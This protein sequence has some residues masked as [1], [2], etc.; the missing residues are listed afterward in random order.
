[1]SMLQRRFGQSLLVFIGLL[2]PLS[3]TPDMANTSI[4]EE[5]PSPCS[6]KRRG[7]FRLVGR[8]RTTSTPSNFSGTYISLT[9]LLY[10][11]FN[12]FLI[13]EIRLPL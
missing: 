1:M 7:G 2:S 13:P 6:P 5:G 9:S 4:Q 8:S 12:R 10:N 3:F 11:T